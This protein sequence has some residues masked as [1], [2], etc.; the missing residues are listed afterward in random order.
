MFLAALFAVPLWLT[1]PAY[2]AIGIVWAALYLPRAVQKQAG[3]YREWKQDLLGGRA[4]EQVFS[5]STCHVLPSQFLMAR[6]G[7]GFSEQKVLKGFML[8]IAFW[9]LRIAQA[10]LFDI[11]RIVLEKLME[12]LADFWRLVVVR[13]LRWTWRVLRFLW[14]DVL[15]PVLRSIRRFFNYLWKNIVLP[16]LSSIR[17]FF[18][19]LWNQ[20]LAPAYRW[21]YERVA[22]VYQTIIQR[23]NREA[24]AD[25]EVLNRTAKE[26]K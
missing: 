8:D 3:R 26:S 9:P 18:S 19:H 1:L 4:L 21:V 2:F 20:V 6:A 24:I 14:N 13:L 16:A 23:A 17:R 25:L 22:K 15:I 12:Y 11:I 10:L 5:A 7:Q